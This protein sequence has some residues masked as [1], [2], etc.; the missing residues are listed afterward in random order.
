M[1]KTKVGQLLYAEFG[2]KE[3]LTREISANTMT[4]LVGV[5][6][7]KETDIHRRNTRVGKAIGSLDQ[8]VF[9]LIGGGMAIMS[10]NRPENLHQPRSFRLIDYRLVDDQLRAEALAVESRQAG[11]PYAVVLVASEE[12][13]AAFCPALP[14][15]A[16]Q[17]DDEEAA[18]KNI[19]EAIVGWLVSEGDD[20]ERRTLDMLD[21]YRSAGY[22]ANLVKIKLV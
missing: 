11:G 16:S 9:T 19:E 6:G 8:R 21:E 1:D 4:Q 20:V 18:I 12:G 7:I 10:V 15:C 2:N 14:G 3:F 22:S 13:W 5:M 17:G